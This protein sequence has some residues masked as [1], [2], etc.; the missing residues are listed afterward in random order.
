MVKIT[1]G[2]DVIEVTAGAFNTIYKR[3]GYELVDGIEDDVIEV[4]EENDQ[5]PSEDEYAEDGKDTNDSDDDASEGDQNASEDNA[6]DA[7]KDYEF[8]DLITKPV[9]QWSKEEMQRY[10]KA[11]DIDTSK[12]K[13][14]AEAKKI[15]AEYIDS[16]Q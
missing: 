13:N 14:V 1:N 9:S 3:Q 12:A 6:D 7:E 4:T 2:V 8:A 15:I 5:K 11:N 10:V 16:I